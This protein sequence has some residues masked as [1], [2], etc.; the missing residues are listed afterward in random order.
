MYAHSPSLSQRPAPSTIDSRSSFPISLRSCL[1]S[2]SKMGTSAE[3]RGRGAIEEM[4]TNLRHVLYFKK[5]QV[6]FPEKNIPFS[7]WVSFSFKVLFPFLRPIPTILGLVPIFRSF[8]W[9][10]VFFQKLRRI[11]GLVSNFDLGLSP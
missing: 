8:F 7:P 4:G 11:L 1:T 9:Y 6:I 5:L 2:L 3:S 10:Y